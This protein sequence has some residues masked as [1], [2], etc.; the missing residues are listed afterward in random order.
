MSSFMTS[1]RSNCYVLMQSDD[2]VRSDDKNTLYTILNTIED[3]Q[4]AIHSCYDQKRMD[5]GT[6]G[7]MITRLA[8][9]PS[10]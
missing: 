9:S 3:Q 7:D 6:L 10:H 2:Y 5:R 4:Q 8:T 1:M